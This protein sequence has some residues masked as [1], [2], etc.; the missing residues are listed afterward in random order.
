MKEKN[1]VI[2]METESVREDPPR[3]HLCFSPLIKLGGGVD[4][5]EIV[6]WPELRVL[7]EEDVS[8]NPEGQ[9]LGELVLGVSGRR[10]SEDVVE[11]LESAL[12]CF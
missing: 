11:F 9:E 7:L 2:Y 12:F 10:H 3:Y 4:L 5:L 8:A 6:Q 1:I